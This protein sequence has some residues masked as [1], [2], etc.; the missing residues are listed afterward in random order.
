MGY[1]QA[2][3]LHYTLPNVNYVAHRTLIARK[4]KGLEDFIS[5]SSVHWH[6]GENGKFHKH[7]NQNI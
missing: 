1:V 3:N 2:S 7:Q 4:L 6:L 5:F